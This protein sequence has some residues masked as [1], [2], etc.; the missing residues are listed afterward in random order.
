MSTIHVGLNQRHS[1][2]DR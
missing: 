2:S 1:H